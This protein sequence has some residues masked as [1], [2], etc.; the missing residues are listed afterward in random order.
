MKGK[1]NKNI[2]KFI[3]ESYN[4][5]KNTVEIANDL[6]TYNTTIRRILMRNNVRI[7]NYS[8]ANGIV[9]GNPF[10]DLEDDQT[11]YWL[12]YI[13][14]DG[15]VSNTH[16]GI[17]LNC[18]EKDKYILNK[19]I[20][21]LNSKVRIQRQ[22]NKKYNIFEYSVGFG[23]EEVKKFLVNLGITPRK[24]LTLELKIPISYSLL[25]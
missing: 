17:R 15:N 4:K 22:F 12:G 1:Y 9:K 14:T 11:L 6:K 19:Y 2:V 5:G 13:A 20:K 10:E 7:R 8:E 3:I 23:N 18:G 25:R 16:N 21:F 24:S